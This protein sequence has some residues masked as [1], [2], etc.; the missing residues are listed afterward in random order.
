M[1]NEENK[2]LLDILQALDGIELH[3]GNKRILPEYINNKTQQ[4]AVE[5]E[6]E[7]IGEAVIICLK[8]IL[9]FPFRL[10]ELLLICAIK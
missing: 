7:I 10:H 2:L 4:R 1:T 3:L 9:K 5:R 6:L 8:S